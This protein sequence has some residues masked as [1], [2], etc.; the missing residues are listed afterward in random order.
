LFRRPHVPAR[1]SSSPTRRPPELPWLRRLVAV[2]LACSQVSYSHWTVFG[3]QLLP[4]SSVV[5]EPT[6]RNALPLSRVTSLTA[7]PADEAGTST[8]AS[9]P[10]A[11]YHLRAMFAARSA[12]FW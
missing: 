9:T 2:P 7:R 12:L 4:E 1:P 6:A 11:S 5:P 10:S 3:E 8:I